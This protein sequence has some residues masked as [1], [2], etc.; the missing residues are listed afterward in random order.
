MEGSNIFVFRSH[1]KN[2]RDALFQWLHKFS[3]NFIK[4]RVEI[5]AEEY[6]FQYNKVAVKDQNTRWGS[7][8]SKKNLNF[9]WRLI[10]APMQVLDYVIIHEFSH[11]KEMNHSSRF[12]D[13]VKS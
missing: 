10:F 4:E 7:C 13:L 5:L 8:S 6:G 3:K 2:H 1:Q 11:L 9:S 12:W